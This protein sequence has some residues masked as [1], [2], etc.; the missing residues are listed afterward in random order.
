MYILLLLSEKTFTGGR[1]N[2]KNKNHIHRSAYNNI[3][4]YEAYTRCFLL[5]TATG[6]LQ[7]T[8]GGSHVSIGRA[9]LLL[10]LLTSRREVFTVPYENIIIIIIEANK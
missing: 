5:L 6:Q 9:I 2:I 1:S 4:I 7:V 8:T 3:I 10:L